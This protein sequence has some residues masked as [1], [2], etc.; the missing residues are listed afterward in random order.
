MAAE[1]GLRERKKQQT[2]ER[3]FETARRLFEKKGFDAISVAEIAREADVSE[4][5]V[6]NYFPTKEDLFYGGMQF[7][8][9]QLLEAVRARPRG[10][11]AVRAFCGALVDSTDGLR[12]RERA[13]AILKSGKVVAAS[14]SL[15]AR[16]RDIVDRYAGRLAA[17]LAGETRGSADDVEAH[18]VAAALMGAHRALVDHVRRQVL[19]GVRGEAL[20]RDARAQIRRACARLESGLGGYAVRA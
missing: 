4:V 3:I 2:R 7:F 19:A 8:E 14:P 1:A 5:T 11:S 13:A 12:A 17:L 15:V 20:V 10:V 6:F 9:E 16:E 18:A